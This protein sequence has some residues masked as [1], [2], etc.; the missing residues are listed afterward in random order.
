MTFKSKDSVF[1][2]ITLINGKMITPK[3]EALHRLINWFNLKYNTNIIA[4]T[5][6]NTNLQDNNWLAGFL[7]A[8]ARA[9]RV[10]FSAALKRL[11]K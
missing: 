4:L 2:V 8:G 11:G 7:D 1:K 5:L 10:L 9:R 6:D 3:V